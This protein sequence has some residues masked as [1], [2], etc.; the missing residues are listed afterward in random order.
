LITLCSPCHVSVHRRQVH[1]RVVAD[2]APGL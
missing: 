1:K 2:K